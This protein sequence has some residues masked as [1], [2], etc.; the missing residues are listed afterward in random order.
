MKVFNKNDLSQQSISDK[1]IIKLLKIATEDYVIPKDEA[2]LIRNVLEFADLDVRNVMTPRI[3]IFAL[4]D[5]ISFSKML[6]EVKRNKHSKIPIYK[7]SLDNIV[8]VIY[9]RDLIPYFRMNKDEIKIAKF[10]NLVKKVYFVH[11]KKPLKILLKDFISKKI[12]IAIV[13]DE[14]GGTEGIITL[15]DIIEKLLGKFIEEDDENIRMV[16][17]ISNNKFLVL[18]ECAISDFIRYTGIEIEDSESETIAGYVLEKFDK[19]P[20]AGEIISDNNCTYKVKNV[21]Q[22]KI[23]QIIVLAK[24]SEV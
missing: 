14:Y 17:K 2:H 7:N 11:E 4:P 5:N 19:I 15:E 1:D 20:D 21:N 3:N 13:I 16:S 18:G 24:E 9:L 8:G 6:F 22:N 10:K 12:S 23:E